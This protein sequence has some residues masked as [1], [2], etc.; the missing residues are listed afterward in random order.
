MIVTFISQC[1]K[2]SL[3]L[4]RQI[5]DAYAN[6]IGERT[7]QTVITQ[8]GLNA[9]K[10]RLA[11]TARK[12][13]AVACHRIHGTRQTELVW[14][15]GNKREFD[16]AGNVPVNRTQR[17]LLKEH[18]ENDWQYLE[19]VKVLVA[20]S[21][22]FHD[23][24]KSWKP[25]QDLLK[26]K[27][28]DAIRHEWISLLLFRAFVVGRSDEEWLDELIAL[29]KAD[30]KTLKACSQRL[31]KSPLPLHKD[32]LQP[33][34][35]LSPLSSWV[36]WLIV[37]HHRLP[38]LKETNFS[39]GN[40]VSMVDIFRGIQL[41]PSG[42]LKNKNFNEKDWRFTDNLPIASAQW[43][44]AAGRWAASAKHMLSQHSME[45][46][47]P[48]AR[49][50]LT[51]ARLSLMLGDHHYSS[52]P[53]KL[54]WSDLALYANTDKAD[55]EGNKPLKQRLDEHL[56]NVAKEA[57]RVARLLPSI[58]TRLARVGNIRALRKPSPPAYHWQNKAVNTISAWKKDHDLSQSGFFALNMASTGTGKTFAN[59]KIM[60][61]L[62]DDES[63]RYNLALGLRT[64]TLQTGDEYREKIFQNQTD[65]DSELAV[66]VGSAAVQYLHERKREQEDHQKQAIGSESAQPIDEFFESIAG[67]TI[68]D[69]SVLETLFSYSPNKPINSKKRR[70]LDTPIIVSTIDHLMPAT[71]GVRGGQ[72]I[73]PTLR[74]MS[75][76]L[77]IDEVD[78]FNEQDFPAI[79]RLVHL[80]G[81][82]GRRVMISSATIPP[83]IAQGLY[84][85]YQA[86]WAIFAITRGRKAS[87]SAL[88]V[89]EF[90]TTIQSLANPNDFSF[91]HQQFI[92]ERSKQLGALPAKRKAAIKHFSPLAEG[93]DKALGN[94]EFFGKL[95][96]AAIS[97]HR[98]HHLR[99][100]ATGKAIS[101]GV[102]RLA[103]VDPCM[104]MARYLLNCD[105]PDDIEIRVIAYHA[106]QVLLLRN[107]LENYLDS[108]LKRN[109]ETKV[110]KNQII[111]QHLSAATKPHILFIV[112]ASPVEEVGRDHDFDWAVIEPSSMR[113]IIQMSGRVLRHRQKW[114]DSPNIAL[115]EYNL[116]SFFNPDALAF[117]RPG[118]ESEQHRLVGSHSLCN[119]LDVHALAEKIDSRPRIQANEPLHPTQR[120]DDLEH[121]VLNEL[122]LSE[123][124]LPRQAWGWLHSDYYLSLLP[125]RLTP[126]RQQSIAESIYKLHLTEDDELEI[127]SP[128]KNGLGKVQAQHSITYLNASEKQR[129]WLSLDYFECIEQQLEN[130]TKKRRALCEL[131]GEFRLPDNEGQTSF[132]LVFELGFLKVHLC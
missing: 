51:L 15:V 100:E 35:G 132:T 45:Q 66:L 112:V 57:L 121:S 39:S 29:A 92:Q 65:G 129:I 79:V 95:L 75:S 122:L 91:A 103:N 84:Q 8:E 107:E 59:A 31:I 9:V 62:S 42:Y 118:F 82:L 2:N 22:L 102:I 113:S 101:L 24:G 20:L 58:E 7:W 14:I 48:I 106:R 5:L 131:L 128:D 10:S 46:L 55:A 74:L 12:T 68:S 50:N 115:P 71:E 126:F 105:L 80:V 125:Q 40:K 34:K 77:V 117:Y 70:F 97:L 86:G 63:L 104:G 73:L 4:T 21:A 99:D 11:K 120:L 61:A 44:E 26:G 38:D 87:I 67:G 37:S 89:D 69:D 93:A 119:V 49:S 1:Q 52:M 53:A 81:M 76:D 13:T 110:F 109:D 96:E 18:L 85:A 83:A 3:K 30:A 94:T 41:E 56:V 19:V 127:R 116:K 64:L 111:R 130:S 114:I 32:V 54:N 36:G 33:L 98:S 123:K 72:Q 25:F 27:G 17:D 16:F 90:K 47:Q 43:C 60:Y 28:Q 6:R 23:F 78:D 88:W 124:H 108:V